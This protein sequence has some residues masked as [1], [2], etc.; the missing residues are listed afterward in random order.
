MSTAK[1]HGTDARSIIR[2]IGIRH[3]IWPVLAGTLTFLSALSLTVVSAWLI[4]R[5]WQMPPIMDI[6]VAVT[7]V[8]A[9]GISRS[10]FRYID[11]LASHSVALSTATKTR[12]SLW[13][14]LAHARSTA[15][16]SRGAV[17]SRLGDDLDAVADVVVRSVIPMLVAAVTSLLAVIFTALLSIP[18]AVVLAVGLTLAGI[19][20]PAIIYRGVRASEFAHA[21]ALE[22]HTSAIENVLADAPSLRIHG[23]LPRALQQAE[24]TTMDLARADRAGASAIARGDGLSMTA[25]TL[26]AIATVAIALLTYQ[27]AHSPEWLTVLVL[28]PLAAFESVSVLPGAAKSLARAQ[29]S[30]ASLE[31]LAG[32]EHLVGGGEPAHS[33]SRPSSIQVSAATTHGVEAAD[34]PHLHIADLVTGY[35][36]D[37]GTWDLDLPFGSRKQIVAP[38]GSGKTTLLKTV[39]GLIPPRG[40][41]VTVTSA[42]GSILPGVTGG[43]PIR[44]IAEDEHIF[45]TTIR[46]NIAIGNPT[47]TDDALHQLVEELGLADWI[48]TL[49]HGLDTVLTSGGESLSGGQRRRLLLARALVS[50]AP[51]LLL[52]EPTE[53]IDTDA[54]E[55]LHLLMSGEPLPGL[56]PE[57]TIVVVRHPR[58]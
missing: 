19:A 21:A 8:R 1:L 2:A 51:I 4:T 34:S 43:Y 48:A 35:D 39:A 52:D 26:T 9:L 41:K 31:H 37:L 29:G 27:G 44:F 36:R 7:A 5:S 55:I 3:L 13:D 15:S 17:L 6:T 28:I 58:D 24:T 12:L 38:S 45:A 57:R 20:A 47:V 10:V 56:L 30:L 11:R 42:D 22:S 32:V 49:P 46:D 23:T 14:S 53:H 18:A 50:T 25:S 33:T 54:D 40:G 16:F